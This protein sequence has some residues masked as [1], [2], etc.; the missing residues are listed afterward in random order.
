M[1]CLSVL[2]VALNTSCTQRLSQHNNEKQ[3][4]ISE[5]CRAAAHSPA[6]GTL[7]HLLQPCPSQSD[8]AKIRGSASPWV[9]AQITVC[10]CFLFSEKQLIS[11]GLLQLPFQQKT[12]LAVIAALIATSESS[13]PHSSPST[14][15]F[16]YKLI[17]PGHIPYLRMKAE[18]ERDGALKRQESSWRSPGL[19]PPRLLPQPNNKMGIWRYFW[20]QLPKNT[21]IQ[22]Y[23]VFL[24]CKREQI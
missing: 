19:W 23:G 15:S 20:K 14:I 24:V 3:R 13:Q 11:F 4:L 5:A 7:A 17:E 6:R 21:S 18:G 9:V 10:C 8:H 16:C 2:R 1:C 12:G 22:N